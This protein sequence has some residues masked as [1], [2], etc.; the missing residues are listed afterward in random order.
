MSTVDLFEP[1]DTVSECS[2]DSAYQSQSGAS[3][4]SSKTDGH[5]QENRRHLSTQFI[6]SD[7]YS[8][9]MSSDNYPAYS[10][11]TLDM[12]QIP[13]SATTG[14]WEATEGP[15]SYA[16]YSAGQ[17]YT[18]YSASSM[19]RFTP[20]TAVNV[21]SQ[22]ASSDAQFQA[23][24]FSF[25]SYPETHSSNDMM[26]ASTSQP[27]WSNTSYDAIERPSALRAPSSYTT[28]GES[29]RAS[30]HDNFG[31]FVATPT[32]TTSVHFPHNVDYDQPQFIGPR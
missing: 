1:K 30:A 8:P 27:Q 12:N 10:E 31:A 4:H 16:N 14:T 7:I 18:H 29:R 32:S 6:G 3:R 5:S 15:L 20:S 22:W 17:D 11:Q 2:M 28:K 25:T 23:H 9:S 13:H 26:F 24:P 19:P 21:P